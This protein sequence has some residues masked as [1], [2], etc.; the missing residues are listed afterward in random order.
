MMESIAE[1]HRAIP[2]SSGKMVR[3][4]ANMPLEIA[5]VCTDGVRVE[6]RF[7]PQPMQKSSPRLSTTTF[8]SAR[9]TSVAWAS[10]S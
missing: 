6:E 2:I 5:L 10:R 3:F 7:Q 1:Q 4:A 8:V 9:M